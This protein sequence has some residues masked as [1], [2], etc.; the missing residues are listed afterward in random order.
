M[1]VNIVKLESEKKAGHLRCTEPADGVFTVTETDNCTE[2]V[3]MDVSGMAIESVIDGH[4]TRSQP[5]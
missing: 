2:K 3:T 4:R 5:S 1:N